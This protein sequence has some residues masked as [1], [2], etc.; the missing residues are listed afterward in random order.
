MASFKLYLDTRTPRKD[1]TFP[2]KIAVNHRSR[3]LI[4]LKTYTAPENFIAGEVIIPGSPARQKNVNA[5]IKGRIAHVENTINKLML[6]GQLPGLTDSQLKRLL[7]T[8]SPVKE[9]GP[10]LLRDH[11]EKF[12]AKKSKQGTKGI[13]QHTLNRI[14]QFCPLD[15]LTFGDITISWLDAFDAELAKT[16]GINARGVHMRNIRA[17]INDAIRYDVIDQ[18][19]YPFRKWKIRKEATPKRSLTAEQ[20]RTIRD[21]ECEPFMEQY[22]DMFMLIFYLIGINA[23]DLFHLKEIRN[24]RIEFRRSKTGRLYSVKVE[25]EALAIIDKYRGEKYLLN[26]SERYGNYKDYLH[27]LNNNLK[28]IGPVIYVPNDTKPKNG[29][30]N[31]GPDKKQL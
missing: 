28:K 2:L 12:I 16:C 21:F 20:I 14:G 24:G 26:V 29:R 17:V 27:R 7:D 3:F 1:G 10:P 23:V 19:H 18:N 15:T 25:P 4:N 9:D 5:Y 13:Y 11:F 8:N 6:L 30:T 22:R 31:N